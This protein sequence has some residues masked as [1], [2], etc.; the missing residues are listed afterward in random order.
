MIELDAIGMFL[1]KK[2]TVSVWRNEDDDASRCVLYRKRKCKYIDRYVTCEAIVIVFPNGE[3][4][5]RQVAHAPIFIP[6]IS[7]LDIFDGRLCDPD[8]LNNACEALDSYYKNWEYYSRDL[9]DA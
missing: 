9:Q 4:K 5:L 2:W 6:N 3:I 1:A 8:C 7:K